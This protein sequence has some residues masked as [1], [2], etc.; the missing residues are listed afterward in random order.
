MKCLVQRIMPEGPCFE[1][2]AFSSYT[3]KM[4][5]RPI[6]GICKVGVLKLSEGYNYVTINMAFSFK[7]QFTQIMFCIT[8]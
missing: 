6:S 8:R 2:S 7:S 1:T 5:S 4:A 3:L